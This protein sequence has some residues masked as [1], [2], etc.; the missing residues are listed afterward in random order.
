[1]VAETHKLSEEAFDWLLGEVEARFQQA[2]VL[3]SSIMLLYQNM[4]ENIV[5]T[6]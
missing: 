5:F 4:K 2:Q 3:N 6:K 1:M